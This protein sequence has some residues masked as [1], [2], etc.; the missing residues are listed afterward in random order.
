MGWKSIFKD[1]KMPQNQSLHGAAG[2]LRLD[3][4]IEVN[5]WHSSPAAAEYLSNFCTSI[6]L[7][8][9]EPLKRK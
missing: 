1:P 2:I 4:F 3:S 7:F 5:L 9:N 8:L 6:L